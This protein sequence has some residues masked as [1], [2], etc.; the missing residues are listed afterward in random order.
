M[1]EFFRESKGYVEKIMSGYPNSEVAELDGALVT[2][3][4][5]STWMDTQYTE[6]KGKPVEVNALWIN[7]LKIAEQMGLKPPVEPDVAL[8]EFGR[9]WNE[10]KGCLYDIIDPY[11]D[12]VRP[13]QAI[14]VALGVMDNSKAKKAME[15]V[16]EGAAYAVWPSDA[17]A[18]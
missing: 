11:D 10:K 2:V 3:A 18:R 7:A 12:A 4:P 5:M 6:R 8:K 15:V 16:T 17:I 1:L 14:A 13:N 9:F